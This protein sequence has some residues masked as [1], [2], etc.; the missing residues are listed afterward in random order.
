[1]TNINFKGACVAPTTIDHLD[2]RAATQV[3]PIEVD[4][5]SS[6]ASAGAIIDAADDRIISQCDLV[7]INLM[8]GLPGLGVDAIDNFAGFDEIPPIIRAYNGTDGVRVLLELRADTI[9]R[10]IVIGNISVCSDIQASLC[11][12][13]PIFIGFGGGIIEGTCVYLKFRLQSFHLV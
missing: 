11:E 3:E 5:Q 2:Q 9:Y 1:M 12:D 4:S 13:I 7:H 10:I 8:D 6:F